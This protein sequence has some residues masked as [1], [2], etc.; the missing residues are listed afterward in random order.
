MDHVT[1]RRRVQRNLRVPRQLADRVTAYAAKLGVSDNSGYILLLT[2]A[3]Q[4]KENS[5]AR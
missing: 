5:D 3:L 1:D 4:A 2:E